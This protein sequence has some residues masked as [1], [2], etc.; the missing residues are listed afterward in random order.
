MI[1]QVNTDKNIKG[2]DR[3]EAFVS[4]K[5]SKSMKRYTDQITR[6]EVHLSDQNAVKSGKDDI[7][8]RIEARVK[9]LSPVAVNSKSEKIDLAVNSAVGKLKSSLDSLTGKLKAKQLK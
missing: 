1:I 8:C 4:E 6:L 5:I 3:L 2:S 9:G 7:Q